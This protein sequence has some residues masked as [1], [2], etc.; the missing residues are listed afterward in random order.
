[1]VEVQRGQLATVRFLR[2]HFTVIEHLPNGRFFTGDT[3][4]P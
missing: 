4:I 1:M 3:S 2:R